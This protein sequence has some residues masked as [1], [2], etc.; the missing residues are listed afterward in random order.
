M[1]YLLDN[2]PVIVGEQVFD[3][4]FGPGVVDFASDT[5]LRVRFPT[6][7]QA[8]R[9]EGI[10]P[11]F[12]FRTL[13][14]APPLSAPPPKSPTLRLQL[15]SAYQAVAAAVDGAYAQGKNNA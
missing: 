13:F 15:R 11:S 10:S 7:T 14:W 6:H 9:P 5:T 12:L 8:Y 3:Y 2:Q 4:A 1:A